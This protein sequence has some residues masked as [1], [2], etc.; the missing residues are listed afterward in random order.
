MAGEKDGLWG[1]FHEDGSPMLEET[2]DKGK[3]MKVS[4]FTDDDGDKHSSGTIINGEGIKIGY[5]PDGTKFSEGPYKN[6]LP[7]GNWT[8]FDER[9]R[10]LSTGKLENGIKEGGWNI[11]AK[12]GKLIRIE[13]YEKGELIDEVNR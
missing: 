6:G 8:F 12:N 5:Y 3:L 13:V 4:E 10:K 9:G 11:Y 2:Y 7:N 1:Y